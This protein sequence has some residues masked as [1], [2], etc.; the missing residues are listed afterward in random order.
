VLRI[1]LLAATALLLVACAT[2]SVRESAQEQFRLGNYEQAIAQ[3]RAG[4]K[5][6]PDSTELRGALRFAID[7]ATTRLLAS[8]NAERSLKRW[9]RAE[10]QVKRLIALD[11][12]NER[13]V[14]ALEDINRDRRLEAKIAQARQAVASGQH[15][16]GAELVRQGLQEQPRNADLLNLQRQLQ[17]EEQRQRGQ[18]SGQLAETRPVTLEF[19]DANLRQ[20]L[21]VL[22]RETKVN[23]VVDKD[24][25]PDLRVTV[26]LRNALLQDAIDLIVGTHQLSRK[27]LDPTTVLVYP[28]TPEK[29]R[30]Y[31][32][33]VV[34]SFFLAHAD[35]KQ[36]AG[37]LRSVLRIREPFVDDRLNLIVVRETPEL[38]QLAERLIAMYDQGE[39]EVM[40]E[41]EVLE[42]RR[43]RLTELGIDFP[44]SVSLTPLPPPGSSGL[45]LESIS[46]LNSSTIGVGVSGIL[47]NLRREVGDVTVLA[48]P[49]IR[50]KNR[51]KA[52][53]LVG[54]RL[55]VITSSA[56]PNAGFVSENIQYVD[57]GI[58]VDFE[59]LVSLDREVTIKVSLEA[60]ALTREIRTNTGSLAYQI[61]TRNAAT[62]LKL[63]DGETQILG[64]LISNEERSSSN[65]LPGLGDVPGMGR[66]FSSQRDDNQRT[67]IILAIT[68]RILRSVERPEAAVAEFFSGSETLARTAPIRPATHQVTAPPQASGGA[69]V[70]TA[71]VPTPAAT[72]ATVSEPFLK[73]A[74]VAA[75]PTARVGESIAIDASIATNIPLRGMPLD[76]EYDRAKLE[77]LGVDEGAFFKQGGAST[78]VSRSVA[79]DRGQLSFGS[80]RDSATGASGEG[81]LVTLK[82]RILAPGATEVR[83]ESATPI[84]ALRIV[85]AP[86]LLPAVRIEGMP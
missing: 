75:A 86:S 59:P 44:D 24:V 8:A 47:I 49:R 3:L 46:N 15:A 60:S 73:L 35:A 19:R 54:E 17:I 31:Q 6:S 74:L 57:V 34:R 51:E 27:V 66:L 13:A 53:I 28:N 52:R 62:T 33:L 84:G 2:Q 23:F 85:D 41:V 68:P 63:R 77:L 48:N 45:T 29:A 69:S 5:E 58:K 36:A 42:V 78:S 39:A 50:A 1:F 20:V 26:F 9:D 37:L 72:Q 11:P 12:G 79:S 80:L 32:D 38:V 67:E 14:I 7:E 82:F 22:S 18:A 30:E 71:S 70:A 65:R 81:S 76:I 64:G 16:R 43:T 55:P 4:L 21:E 25:R 56:A 40:L 61:G 10:A 83:I